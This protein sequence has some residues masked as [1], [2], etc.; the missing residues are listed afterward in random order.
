MWMR[1]KLLLD[2]TTLSRGGRNSDV[3]EEISRS[4]PSMGGDIEQL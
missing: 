2:L 1:L 3:D 4:L